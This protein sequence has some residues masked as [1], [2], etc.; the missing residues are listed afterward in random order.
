MEWKILRK[1]RYSV[2][3]KCCAAGRMRIAVLAIGKGRDEP[4]MRLFDD[5]MRRLPW[6]YDLRELQEKRPLKAAQLKVCEAELLLGAVPE[7]AITV[8]LDS[9]GKL[10]SSEDFA[11]RLGGWR[12]DGAASVAFLIGGAEGHGDEVLKTANFRLSLGVMTWPH[13][14]VRAMLAEQLWRAASILSG[15]PYHRN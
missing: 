10:L 4:T 14:L 9:G 12:D 13:M 1:V 3:I 11:Y 15:H 7:Q 6:P 2:S 8:A 5:Y